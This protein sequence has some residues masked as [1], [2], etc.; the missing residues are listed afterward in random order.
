MQTFYKPQAGMSKNT[1][2]SRH[3]TKT[4]LQVFYQRAAGPLIR[5][6]L[7]PHCGA[8]TMEALPQALSQGDFIKQSR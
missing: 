7:E 1:Q 8:D 6:E 4:E 3:I 5:E 2:A